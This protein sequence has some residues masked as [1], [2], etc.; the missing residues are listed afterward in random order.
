MVS[1]E[2]KSRNVTNGH[3]NS[4]IFIQEGCFIVKNLIDEREKIQAHRLRHRIFCQELGW[5]PQSTDMLEID[6]YDDSAVFLGVFD[7]Q[8]KLVAFL[9]FVL[10]EKT[11]MI[12]KTFSSLIGLEH[13]IRKEKDTAEIS[14]LC[15]VPEARNNII[16]GNFG[17]HTI[18]MFLYKGVYHWC[19]RNGIRYLYLV[20][21][22]KV[23]RLLYAKGFP[24]KMI[25]A[26]L[27]LEDSTIAVAA[28]IDLREFESVNKVKRPEMMGWF[29]SDS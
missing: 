9:R 20:A 23:Y 21:E 11:F 19:N 26:P 25:G 12:E 2:R 13:K 22:H 28:I 24:C 8:D 14:R 16:Y 10:P 1:V 7:E 17:I 6:D 15:I 27:T 3:A 4:S 18:S 29:A 5:V